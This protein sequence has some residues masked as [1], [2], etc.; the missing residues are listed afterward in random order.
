MCGSGKSGLRRGDPPN[1]PPSVAH[2]LISMAKD[3]V[4]TKHEELGVLF[5]LGMPH[6][7]AEVGKSSG[8]MRAAKALSLV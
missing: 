5:S 6:G 1:P 7:R 4:L 3:F 8:Y 2:D